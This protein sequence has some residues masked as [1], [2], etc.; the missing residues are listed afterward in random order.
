M[1]FFFFL[2]ITYLYQTLAQLCT[3]ASKESSASVL[4]THNF[5]WLH[6]VAKLKHKQTTVAKWSSATTEAEH[7]AYIQDADPGL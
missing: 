4:G 3:H 5:I 6:P 2:A 7:A 1:H